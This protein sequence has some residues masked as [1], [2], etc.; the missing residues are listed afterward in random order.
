MALCPQ[1]PNLIYKRGSALFQHSANTLR[2]DFFL[3]Y[4]GLPSITS[5]SILAQCKHPLPTLPVPW[6]FR[7]P[8]TLVLTTLS[9]RGIPYV[10]V[11]LPRSWGALGGHGL[12]AQ[13]VS[14]FPPHH[15]KDA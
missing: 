8:S 6:N 13:V 9:H 10:C 15:Q 11:C 2:Q 3:G 12:Y 4:T 14:I 7:F 1:E 5:A